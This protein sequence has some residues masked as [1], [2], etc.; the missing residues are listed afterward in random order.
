MQ[1][2]TRSYDDAVY[3]FVQH[4][5]SNADPLVFAEFKKLQRL[6][7]V[8]LQNELATLKGDIHTSEKVTPSQRTDLRRLLSEYSK[9][10]IYPKTERGI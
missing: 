4:K 7:L 6:N 5:G 9:Y 8:E 2:A 1:A 3:D 10:R